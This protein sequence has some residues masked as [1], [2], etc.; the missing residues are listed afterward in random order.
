[1]HARSLTLAL[2]A[3]A[4]AAAM[5]CS[6]EKSGTGSLNVHLVD[7]PGDYQQINLHVLE[8]EVHSDQAGWVTISRPD[9]TYDLLTLRGG[10]FATLASGAAL[11]AGDYG[12]VR[13]LLG[14]GNTVK[15]ADG[16]VHD[17]DVPSGMQSGLKLVCRSRVADGATTDLFI[18]F[19]G[20]R[21]IFLHGTGSGKHILR[22]VV[23]CVEKA[24]AGSIRGQ[25]LTVEGE[26]NVP[27][28]GAAV[29]AQTLDPLGSPTVVRSVTT[30]ADGRYTLDLLPLGATYFV[31][32]QPVVGAVAYAARA[33]GALA[34]GGATTA[35]FDVTYA[36]P[37]AAGAISG[38]VSPAA[39]ASD[40]DL[41]SAVQPLD[42][43]GTSRRFVVRSAVPSAVSGVESYSLAS[44]PVGSYSLS[45]AR[46]TL[47][48]SGE[49]VTVGAAR[50]AAVADGLTTTVNLTVP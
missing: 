11:P 50:E 30:G 47:S 44:L 1:M 7:A 41:V 48:A 10:I 37:V 21:S 32:T 28:A 3:G 22:P 18:D 27:L 43:A 36:G 12:Q 25:L 20:H 35:A 2:A 4:L 8:V 42:S 40:A 33:S 38:D 6:S 5:G 46:R 45:L 29:T 17:L 31:V 23:R 24:A 9:Q 16:T 19:D 34:L 13:L 39:S 49:T 15:L 14:A 26:G